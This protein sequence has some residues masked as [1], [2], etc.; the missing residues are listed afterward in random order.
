MLKVYGSLLCPDCVAC[1]AAF[2]EKGIDFE[3]HDFGEELGA[4]KEFLSIRDSDPQFEAVK[5]AGKIGIPCIRRED[6][7]VSLD[8]EAFV[9][10]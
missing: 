3:Y 10:M 5:Q 7:T 2:E 6:G 9:S 4:L 1:K 8:W